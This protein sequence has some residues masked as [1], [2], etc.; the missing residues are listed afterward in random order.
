MF[1]GALIV[2]G[3]KNSEQ[4]VGGMV[5]VESL[6]VRSE[7]EEAALDTLRHSQRIIKTIKDAQRS[8][9]CSEGGLAK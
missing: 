2:A 6:Q 5:S 4:D 8:V 1:Y 3:V 9:E 7:R